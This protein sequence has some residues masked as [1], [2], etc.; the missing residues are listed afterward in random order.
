MPPDSAG[1][2]KG[3]GASLRRK[4]DIRFLTGRGQYVANIAMP[5]MLEVAFLRAPVAHARLRGVTRPEGAADRV[6]TMADLVGVRPIVANSALPGFRSSQQHPLVFDKVRH[7][8]EPIAACVAETRAL[9]EDL[10]EQVL[11]D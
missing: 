9:A 4:E 10:A 3:V 11:A 5:G 7:V 1:S 8:G 6:F 2:G